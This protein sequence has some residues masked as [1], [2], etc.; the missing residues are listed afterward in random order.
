[1]G[2]SP[3][4]DRQCL[5]PGRESRAK[6]E[7]PA[8]AQLQSQH[9]PPRSLPPGLRVLRATGVDLTFSRLQVLV[10]VLTFMAYTLY[11]ASRKP[12]SIVKGV[13]HPVAVPTLPV[14]HP[15][16]GTLLPPA[17]PTPAGWPPFSGGAGNTLL[18]EL[19]LAFLACY[20]FGMYFSGQLADRLDLRLF[21]AAGMAGSGLF[22]CLFGMAYFWNVHSLPYFLSA[23]MLTGLL[24]STG[25]PSVVAAMANWYGK[26][27]R[28]LI[29]GVW[30]AHTSIGNILGSLGSSAVLH[31]GWGW[32]FILPGLSI[33]AGGAAVYFFMPAEPG[34]AGFESPRQHELALE[35]EKRLP[36]ELEEGKLQGTD[37]QTLR[38]FGPL[39][40]AIASFTSGVSKAEDDLNKSLRAAEAQVPSGTNPNAA[41]AASQGA[42]VNKAAT[43]LNG[44]AGDAADAG[45]ADSS[46]NAALLQPNG[47]SSYSDHQGEGRGGGGE[48]EGGPAKAMGFLEA[49]QI[50]GVAAY[51]FCLFFAKLVAYTFLDW[52]PFYISHTRECIPLPMM[53]CSCP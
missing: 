44:S 36:G 1:M 23:S 6:G 42:P 43:G 38:A 25:W 9:Q 45:D 2:E 37:A 30:N 46:D 18:G 32:A 16:D 14:L 21:L 48:A 12:L 28:G 39:N 27:G 3:P 26:E 8:C 13:L 22:A 51:A 52:L 40:S 20:S 53:L 7:L 4:G 5:T 50:P 29:M 47:D 24:Q 17:I 15:I 34:D 10:W 11:H 31:L 35:A 33:A 19:D 49:W 41:A